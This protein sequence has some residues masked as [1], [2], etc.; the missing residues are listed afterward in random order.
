MSAIATSGN[1]ITFKGEQD[2]TGYWKGL[3]F[4]SNNASNA[5]THCIV[6]NGGSE[7]FDGAN[8]KANVEVW[9]SG[10]LEIT[11]SAFNKSGDVGV[12]VE[13][14][15]TITDSGGNTFTGNLGTDFGS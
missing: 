15:A 10:N 4:L 8:R 11:N 12:R 1:E 5:L 13:G 14:T 9:D 6:E 2:V 7:G 3:R